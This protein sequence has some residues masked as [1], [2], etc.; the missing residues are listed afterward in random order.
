MSILTPI[1]PRTPLHLRILLHVPVLGWMAR[2]VLFGDRNNLWFALIA[3]V[4]V[5]IMAIAAWGIVAVYLPV[6]FLVPA[7]FVLLF[8]VTNG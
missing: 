6:V 7:V 8:L 5:W 2:D 1:P 4:S 3:I